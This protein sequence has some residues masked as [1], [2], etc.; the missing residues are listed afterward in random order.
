M[1]FT[2]RKQNTNLIFHDVNSSP[3]YDLEVP[4]ETGRSVEKDLLSPDT[5]GMVLTV[6]RAGAVP[7]LLPVVT[8]FPLR[9]SL[10]VTWHC[11]KYFPELINHL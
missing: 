4:R 11:F 2:P 9:A 3:I 1:S 5:Q 6:P 7:V 10:G 8:F